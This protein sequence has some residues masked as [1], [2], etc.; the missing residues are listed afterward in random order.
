MI[1]P[2]NGD[3][4]V[5]VSGINE[6]LPYHEALL[7]IGKGNGIKG[8]TKPK[9]VMR[10]VQDVLM[11]EILPEGNAILIVHAQNFRKSWPWLTDKNISV[12]SLAFG[13]EEL[14]AVSEF[15]GL[16][17]I[18]IRDSGQGET[19]EW[20]AIKP[21]DFGF[22]KGLFVM[23][24]RVFASTYGKAE[25]FKNISK[26]ISVLE[27]PE[28]ASWNPGLFELT[29]AIQQPGDTPQKLAFVV[30]LLR[31]MVIQ[32]EDATALPLPL[33]LAKQVEEYILLL[34]YDDDADDL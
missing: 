7:L 11:N 3:V 13:D 1:S 10:F 29:V 27:R 4:L 25:Q 6:W 16:R 2:A 8:F 28:T 22:S 12:D 5:R 26:N 14:R 31:Q 24:K 15:P 30:H 23:S 19:P 33:H 20:Y 9:D 34:N 32:Y 18:R 17:I 21:D